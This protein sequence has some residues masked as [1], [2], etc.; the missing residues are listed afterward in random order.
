MRH[1]ALIFVLFLP[2]ALFGSATVGSIPFSVSSPTNNQTLLFNASTG[3][4]INGAGGGGGSGTVTQ[5]TAGDTTL[6]FSPSTITTTG[7][8]VV[9]TAA[10]VSFHSQTISAAGTA[11]ISP[12]SI[13]HIEETSFTGSAGTYNVVLVSTSYAQGSTV[14]VL[15]KLP[16]ATAGIVINVYSVSTGGTLLFTYT[17]DTVQ[18]NALFRAAVNAGGTYDAI[19]AAAPAF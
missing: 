9:N 8:M 4:W 2:V 11:T 12:T 14:E 10:L 6:T 15:A 19:F 5:L 17:T 7:T 18:P 13:H 16:N 3:F 1:L